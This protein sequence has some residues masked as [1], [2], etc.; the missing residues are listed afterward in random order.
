MKGTKNKIPVGL[1]VFLIIFVVILCVVLL[2]LFMYDVYRFP[3]DAVSN[4]PGT[5]WKCDKLGLEFFVD[6]AGV[7]AGT[8][9]D[10]FDLISLDVTTR[11]ST[12]FHSNYI[13]FFVHDEQVYLHCFYSN[14]DD[15]MFYVT[16]DKEETTLDMHA[17]T[18]IMPYKFTKID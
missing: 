2:S 4:Y 15:G 7:V 14:M 6:D 11:L 12:T 18:E 17:I 1:K 5:H 9:K 16:I 8:Y 10:G 13:Q 3:R